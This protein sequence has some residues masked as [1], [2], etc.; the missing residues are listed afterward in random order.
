SELVAE[1]NE[2]GHKVSIV[3]AAAGNKMTP[4]LIPLRKNMMKR[5]ISNLLSNGIKYGQC[6]ACSLVENAESVELVFADKGPGLPVN[7]LDKVFEPFYRLESS[8]NKTSGG[9]GLGLAICLQIAKAHGGNVTLENDLHKGLI[10]RLTL[11]K[12]GKEYEATMIAQSIR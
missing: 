10:A 8:R 1:F 5:C 3:S 6:V 7:Q 4:L 9:H 2:L 12:S 11:P